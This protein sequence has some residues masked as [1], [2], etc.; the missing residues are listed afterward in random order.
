MQTLH[1]Y[2]VKL[3]A[4]IGVRGLINIQYVIKDGEVLVIEANPRASRTVP[5]LSKAIGHPLAKYAALIAAGK[6]LTE[7][8][9][10]ETPQPAFYSAKEVVLPFLKFKNVLPV[11]G[12][13]M[14]STGE[15]MGIDPDPYMA[16]AKALL[17]A[18]VKLPSS[19]KALVLGDGLDEVKAEL[20]T[21]E[22]TVT[23]ESTSEEPEYDL[24]ID[25]LHTPE[26]RRALEAGL[27]YV[28]TT[29]AARWLVKALRALKER[30]LTVH[31]LQDLTVPGFSANAALTYPDEHRRPRLHVV[32]REPFARL[33]AEAD[34]FRR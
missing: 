23:T 27:P 10:T 30:P 22:F 7:L 19:G 24:L 31:A 4:A 26:L 15:S 2:S 9:F 12:P 25:T 6:S 32:G 21:L 34:T 8:G 3:A 33:K 11:L 18:N 16:Y 1:D 28:T 14:R 29:D 20:G 13:E 17:G 5:Y